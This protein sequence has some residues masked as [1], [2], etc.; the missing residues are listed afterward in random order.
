MS[1]KEYT[2]PADWEKEYWELEPDP[3]RRA[4]ITWLKRYPWDLFVSVNF[5]QK[6]VSLS[7]TDLNGREILLKGVRYAPWGSVSDVETRLKAMDA[8]LCRELLGRYWTSKWNERP[9]WVAFIEKDEDGFA[10]AH[11]LVNLKNVNREEFVTTF[12]KATRYFAPKADIRPR[13]AFKD[14]YTTEGATYYGTKNL[15]NYRKEFALTASPT[16]DKRHRDRQG[17][18]S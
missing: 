9:E 10:H 3:V 5:R 1:K 11:L 6:Q 7:A 8:R 18:A 16:F 12:S 2:Y 4:Y 17:T 13:G 15:K 14:I